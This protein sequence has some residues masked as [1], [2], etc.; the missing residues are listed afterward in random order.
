M[1]DLIYSY[2]NQLKQKKIPNPELDLRILI[3]ESLFEK[4]DVSLSNVE[5]KNINL[6][7]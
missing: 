7:S 3:K 1:N 6:N 5:L 2:L 4:K